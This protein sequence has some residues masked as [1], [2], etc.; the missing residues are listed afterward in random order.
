[1]LEMLG[2]CVASKQ[3]ADRAGAG[4][5]ARLRASNQITVVCHLGMHHTPRSQFESHGRSRVAANSA[6]ASF[7]VESNGSLNQ[8]K[9]AM[10]SRYAKSDDVAGSIQVAATLIPF[11]L[12][13]WGAVHSGRGSPWLTAVLMVLI[14]LF[15]VRAFGLMHEC[16]H[17]SLFRSRRLNRV[18]GFGLGVL[19]GMPQYV[20]SQHHN[21]HHAHNGNWDRY[22][23]PY[24]TL[25]V[26]EYARLTNGQ[27]RLYRFKCGIGA[28]P[29]AGFI[30][31]VFN[32]RFTWVDGSSIAVH[33]VRETSGQRKR[34]SRSLA[35]AFNRPA[36]RK[37]ASVRAPRGCASSRFRKAVAHTVH[38]I[39]QLGLI[40]GIH[41]VTDDRN[42]APQSGVGLGWA[43]TPY[44]TFDLL[45]IDH[46][47]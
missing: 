20:W 1:M 5:R 31:L 2:A 18:V 11:A 46:P 35:C 25:S 36:H 32:P 10:I 41:G 29:L 38:G 47:G 23:G 6:G 15:T 43:L 17:G 44:R 39:E 40:T 33:L 30:Y 34:Q 24:S 3:Y 42:M 45:P 7:I 8:H 13:W 9:S 14:S 37:R 21:Y 28:A 19:S 16:G 22:R 27:Q 12:L 26:D 4:M